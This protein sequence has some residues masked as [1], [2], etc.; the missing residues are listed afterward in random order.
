MFP[1]T[2]KEVNGF[3]ALLPTVTNKKSLIVTTNLEFPKCGGYLYRRADG[4]G[5]D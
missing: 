4:R 3:F 2:A 1:L 5:N